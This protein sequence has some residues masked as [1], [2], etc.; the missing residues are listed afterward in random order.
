M[1]KQAKRE[2]D[3]IDQMY[4]I[5]EDDADSDNIFRGNAYNKQKQRANEELL[6]LRS[7]FIPVQEGD[8]DDSQ[9]QSESNTD[10]R[11]TDR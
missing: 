10:D 6:P 1:E 8:D 9:S 7:P 5:R 3:E 2:L 11:G 4:F